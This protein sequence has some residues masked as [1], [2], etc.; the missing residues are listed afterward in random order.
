MD[1]NSRVYGSFENTAIEQ[2]T[3]LEEEFIRYLR[4]V[5]LD[6]NHFTVWSL[7]LGDLLNNTGSVIDSFLKNAIN[8]D[9][10]D[11]IQNIEKMREDHNMTSYRRIFDNYYNIHDKGIFENKTLSKITPFSSWGN[12]KSPD[13]WKDYTDLKHDRFTNQKKA[14]FKTTLEALG[15]LFLLNV[16]H[17]ETRMILF[18]D[19]FIHAPKPLDHS[20]FREI[21]SK[22]EP[23]DNIHRPIFAKS[24]LFGYVFEISSKKIDDNGKISILSPWFSDSDFTLWPKS[25]QLPP[26][27]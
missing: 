12:D 20:R 2:Y 3:N 8:S 22:I 17:L 14:T 16:I 1:N 9:Q 10:F 5:P 4:Y 6:E 7:V 11:H 18:R 19:G 25:V 13:W 26:D 27:F 15:G 21:V 23:L 24:R